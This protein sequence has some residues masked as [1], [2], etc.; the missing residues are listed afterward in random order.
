MTA[1]VR[2]ARVAGHRLRWIALKIGNASVADYVHRLGGAL[3]FER[4]E[5]CAAN[6]ARYEK[7]KRSLQSWNA[8]PARMWEARL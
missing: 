6:L 2:A 3:L 8:V 1:E 4:A 7:C 5:H